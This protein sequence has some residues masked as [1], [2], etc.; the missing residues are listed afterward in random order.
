MIQR[1]NNYLHNLQILLAKMLL[2]E[3]RTYFSFARQA[4]T[5]RNLSLIRTP[6]MDQLLNAN[7]NQLS[8]YLHK[9]HLSL[10]IYL[11]R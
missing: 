5:V 7:I 10:L 1:M 3:M 4:Q 11:C 6:I 9:Q 2:R 8:L